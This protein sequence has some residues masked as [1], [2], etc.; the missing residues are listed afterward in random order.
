MDGQGWDDALHTPLDTHPPQ[1][2]LP[3]PF[4]LKNPRMEE[5]CKGKTGVKTIFEA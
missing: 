3:K 1:T 5:A 2:A 4:F